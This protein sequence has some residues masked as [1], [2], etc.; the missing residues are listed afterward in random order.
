MG[1]LMFVEGMI[2]THF[3]NLLC[4]DAPLEEQRLS[5]K[6]TKSEA[7]LDTLVQTT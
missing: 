1:N 3:P 7:D 6:V 2:I 5:L 4:D